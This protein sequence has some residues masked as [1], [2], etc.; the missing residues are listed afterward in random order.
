M[1]LLAAFAFLILPPVGDIAD[2]IR[3]DKAALQGSWKVIESVSKGEKVPGDELKDLYLIFKTDAIHIREAG[4]TAE[5]FTFQLDPSKRPK[6]IDVTLR[7]GPQKGRVDRGIYQIDGD[8]L[9]ICIQ[10]DKDQP[11]PREFSSPVNSQL[12]LVILRRAN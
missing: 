8:L 7:V 11:R 4:K 9:R 2:M 5:N 1:N 6:E 10:T 12:W 3:K